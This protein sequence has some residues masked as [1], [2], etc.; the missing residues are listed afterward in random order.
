M[1]MAMKNGIL[2]IV[3]L[4]TVAS[5]GADENAETD[6]GSG[7]LVAPGWET[8][9]ANCTVCHSAHVI[10]YQRGDREAWTS[11]IR[12]MQNTQGLWQFQETTEDTILTYLAASYP[13]G[14]P[15]RRKNLAPRDL[16][17]L[18]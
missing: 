17:P 2:C 6:I 13:P 5:W 12:W 9:K 7:L 1:S 3:L 8:V 11:M 10:T 14:K 16:P 15:T 18:M 4:S